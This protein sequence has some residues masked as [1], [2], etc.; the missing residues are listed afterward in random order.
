MI[1]GK[2]TFSFLCRR[3]MY[4]NFFL[5][6]ALFEFLIPS[7]DATEMLRPRGVSV[8]KAG[9]YSPS[10]DFTCFD[11]SAVIPFLRVNDDYCDCKDGSDE[12]GTAACPNG[13]FHCT[14]AGHQSINIPSSRVNDGVCDCCD[15]SD[16]YDSSANCVNN[17]GELGAAAYAEAMKLAEVSRKGNELR[18]SLSQQGKQMRQEKQ[19]RVQQ[20]EKERDEVERVKQEKEYLKSLAEEAERGALE[21]YKKLEEQEREQRRAEDDNEEER[22]MFDKFQLLDSNHDGKIDM[23]ELQARN[24]FDQNRDG[25]VSEDEA[26]YFLSSTGEMAWE[27]FQ[28]SGY[29]RMKPYFILESGMFKPPVDT[30]EGEGQHQEADKESSSQNAQEPATE[31]EMVDEEALDEEDKGGEE[32]EEEH[33]DDGSEEE[34]EEDEDDDEGGEAKGE[35]VQEPA[36]K[37]EH[38]APKYDEETQR[39][40]DEAN[41]AR[42]EAE[43]ADRASRDLT[44]EMRQIQDSLERD[45]GEEEE[46]A[47]LDGQCHE[48]TDR[49]YTYR[50]CPFDQ[51]TQRPKNG[52]TETR[53][54]TWSG[55]VG[56]TSSS[57]AGKYSRMLYD[58]GQGCWN[59]PQRSTLVHLTCGMEHAV[60]AVSEPN[61]CEYVFE[62]VTPCICREVDDK[63]MAEHLAAHDEL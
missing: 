57:K 6:L 9:L 8:A 41:N 45:Y 49:E 5:F 28:D 43:E 50:L 59:G 25:A 10:N 11:G 13:S 51:A 55:W 40:I 15:A 23:G 46:F 32:G 24:T 29:S 63:N 21:R 34:E 38:D 26:K 58:K 16:E 27:E 19:E 12:P 3:T 56:D 61:R 14:N 17:C 30:H 7:S 1:P 52:G 20:L 2:Y 39:L 4:F 48:Y 47:V 18:L 35:Q 60:T 22:E 36:D 33:L 54:G 31:P 42:A 44:R 62:F 37:E 53:L